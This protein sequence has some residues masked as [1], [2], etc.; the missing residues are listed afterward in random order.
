MQSTALNNLA[1]KGVNCF[2]LTTAC[3]LHIGVKWSLTACDN[4]WMKGT[5]RLLG[6]KLWDFKY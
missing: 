6:L 5:S 1:S 4:A 3:K 2:L